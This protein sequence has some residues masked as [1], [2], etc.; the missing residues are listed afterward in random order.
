MPLSKDHLSTVT[1]CH[2]HQE[3]LVIVG[4]H[5][6][7]LTT[8][9]V[10]HTYYYICPSYLLLHMS[11]ILTTT[12]V[13]HTYYYICPSYLLLHM[14]IILTTT[15]CPSYLLL[16]YVHGARADRLGSKWSRYKGKYHCLYSDPPLMWLPLLPAWSSHI[17]GVVF[18]QGVTYTK[19]SDLASDFG[20]V[21][22]GGGGN[23]IT[24]G[25]HNWGSTVWYQR[26]Y[27]CLACT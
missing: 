8:T 13:H 18:H 15:L 21:I 12:Y 22:T 23:C 3:W 25:S 4:V 14:S 7:I 6:L 26:G 10:H 16:H 5:L 17:R 11:I 24:E 19:L 9:Y 1:A 27:D 2:C 20:S